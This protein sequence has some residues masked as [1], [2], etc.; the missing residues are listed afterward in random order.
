MA[1]I[2]TLIQV[3]PQLLSM[4]NSFATWINKVSGNDPAGFIVKVGAAFDQLAQAETQDEHIAAAQAL[5]NLIN[6]LP[7]K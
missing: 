2:I 7:G 6:S 4:I 3:L 5:S 1:S